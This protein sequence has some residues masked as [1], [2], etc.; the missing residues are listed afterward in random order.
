MR[1]SRTI[2]GTTSYGF[3][4]LLLERAVPLPELIKR[5][6]RAGLAALQICE[7]ARA[8]DA[9]SGAW[10]DAVT[11]ARDEN[12]ELHVGTATLDID[13]LCRNLDL[14]AAI[15]NPVVRIVLEESGKGLPSRET[16]EQFLE[17]AVKRVEAAGMQL[18]IE[19]YFRIPCRVLVEMTARFPERLVGFCIDS[20]NSL[21]NWESAAQVF[22]LLEPRALQF[23]M[24]DYTVTGTNVGFTVT[25]TPLGEGD[26]DLAFCARRILARHTAPRVFLENWVPSSG[27]AEADIAADNQWLVRSLERGR[28][29]LA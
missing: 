23:H 5:T 29:V 15:P 6:A 11:A 10:L 13:T 25:G 17:T 1:D 27:D 14:A 19:N 3:R 21:R 12:V 22:D 20:A 7:N 24:K 8:I 26:L 16:I 28:S 4:Y 9:P 18:A 2:L